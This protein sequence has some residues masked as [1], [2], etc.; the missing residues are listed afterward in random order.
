MM[1]HLNKFERNPL[2]QA[3]LTKNNVELSATTFVMPSHE[4]IEP[5]IGTSSGAVKSLPL[6]LVAVERSR[7]TD[8]GLLFFLNVSE[9][10]SSHLNGNC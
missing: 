5:Y 4:I 8:Q 9:P 10:T 3:A 7:V 1:I 6:V 2:P